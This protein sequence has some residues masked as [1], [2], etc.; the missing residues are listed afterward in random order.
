[1]PAKGS[2]QAIEKRNKLKPDKS[3]DVNSVPNI[4]K[5]TNCGKRTVDP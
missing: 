4:Y 2:K 5:C 1:M 3:F